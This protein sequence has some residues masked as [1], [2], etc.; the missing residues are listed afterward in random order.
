MSKK[1]KKKV[2]EYVI[3]SHIAAPP[4]SSKYPWHEMKAGDSVFVPGGSTSVVYGN[5]NAYTSAKQW[6]QHHHPEWRVVGRTRE[7]GGV[8]GIRIWFVER[9]A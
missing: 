5:T 9:D 3:E 1:T 8:Q 2:G 6:V 4:P 7:E